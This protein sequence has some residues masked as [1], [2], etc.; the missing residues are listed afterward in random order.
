MNSWKFF[1]GTEGG[2]TSRK[3]LDTAT[4][5]IGARSF[6]VFSGIFAYMCG[7]MA[8]MLSWPDNSV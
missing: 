8:S 5:L 7:L 2:T 4:M 6:S 1:T 3:P